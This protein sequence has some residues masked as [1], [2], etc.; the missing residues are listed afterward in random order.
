M[1][2][3]LYIIYIGILSLCFGAYLEDIPVILT[4]PDNSKLSC[5]SS[6]DEYYVRLHN[7][8]DYTIIQN[9]DNGF[10]YYLD[11]D[12]KAL[13][14]LN[15]ISSKHRKTPDYQYLKAECLYQVI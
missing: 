14:H 11:E 3:K 4:Q 1:Y 10:Y 8:E 13:T 9:T 6:G 15:K 7:A 2:K 5:F 12:N